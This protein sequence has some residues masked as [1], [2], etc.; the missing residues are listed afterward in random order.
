MKFPGPVWLLDVSTKKNSVG[1]RFMK[2]VLD[3]VHPV[4][5]FKKVRAETDETSGRLP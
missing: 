5:H 3:R 2:K 1:I 4:K